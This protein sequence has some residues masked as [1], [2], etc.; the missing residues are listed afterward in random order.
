MG[1]D[2]G[3]IIR[4]N[5]KKGYSYLK[6]HFIYL[7]ETS[8]NFS[9]EFGY[10]RKCWNIRE[11]FITDFKYDKENY[12]I[13]F[14]ISDIPAIIDALKCFLNEENWEYNGRTSLVFNWYEELPSIANAIRNLYLFYDYIDE[15]DD[16][17]DVTDEDFD[18]YFYDSY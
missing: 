4:A 8:N 17:D 11:K 3:I 9:Y 6:R 12:L 2:N 5:T 13:T 10:W 14:K 7:Q 15:D 1:L 18:I 16:E